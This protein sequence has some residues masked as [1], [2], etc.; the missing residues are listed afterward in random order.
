[1]KEKTVGCALHAAKLRM[2]RVFF[3]RASAKTSLLASHQ[4]A[5]G[6]T[7]T[8]TVNFAGHAL[9]LASQIDRKIFCLDALAITTGGLRCF[10]GVPAFR[11]K[12]VS[13]TYAV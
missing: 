13:P 12:W 4:I 6:V 7:C 2:R 1:M 9:R 11:S 3:R 10:G 8:V 5:V